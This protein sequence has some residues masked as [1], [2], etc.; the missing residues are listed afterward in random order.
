MG[1]G[2]RYPTIAERFIMMDMGSFGVYDN[3]GLIPESSV[4]TEIGVK[5]GFKFA[6]YFGYLDVA[7]FQQ[8]YK[9]TIE[10]LFG[11]WDTTFTWP[12]YGLR[13]VNT[14]ESRIIGADISVTG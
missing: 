7:V 6:R 10:Y 1:Q 12:F 3:P 9:N 2:Y 8:D 14:G 4:N 5:Q 11:K 13:F